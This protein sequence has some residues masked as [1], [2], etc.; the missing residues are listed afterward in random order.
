[1]LEKREDKSH[2]LNEKEAE[3]LKDQINNLQ[4][5]IKSK[6]FIYWIVLL[7]HILKM[8]SLMLLVETLLENNQ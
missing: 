6:M 7:V 5:V 1:M 4:K 2:H 8:Y 3:M